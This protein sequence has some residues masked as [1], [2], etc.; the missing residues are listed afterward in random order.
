MGFVNP[1]LSDGAAAVSEDY[2]EPAE[3]IRLLRPEC[4]ID[5]VAAPNL[6]SQPWTIETIMGESVRLETDIEF[7]AKKMLHRGNMAT[8]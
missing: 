5:I 2:I 1:R 7:I 3:Y 8:A 4:E 6:S